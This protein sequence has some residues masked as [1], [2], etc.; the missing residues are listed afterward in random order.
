MKTPKQKAD[1][2]A[3]FGV[4]WEE[5]VPRRSWDESYDAV[6]VSFR[7]NGKVPSPYSCDNNECQ[8]GMWCQTQRQ[9]HREGHLSPE[10]EAKLESISGWYWSHQD[11][12]T[13][14]SESLRDFIREEKGVPNPRSKDKRE[15]ELGK[16][17]VQQRLRY[18]RG[19]LDDERI[20]ILEG[21][22]GWYWDLDEKWEVRLLSSRCFLSEHGHFPRRKGGSKLERQ[23]SVWLGNQRRLEKEGKLSR[24]KILALSRLHDKKRISDVEIQRAMDAVDSVKERVE[25]EGIEKISIRT[26]RALSKAKSKGANLGKNGAVLAKRNKETADLFAGALSGTISEIRAGGNTTIR[27]IARELNFRGI[28]SARGGEW[29]AKTVQR[30]LARIDE[31][32]KK[33]ERR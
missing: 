12:W 1:E 29:G 18:G 31:F 32:D 17:C 27:G 11:K 9:R 15:S 26:K 16:W 33:T 4:R 28:P 8:L 23:L 10:Q 13:S 3:L 20:L 6:L 21:I 5:V 22:E 24:D 2:M 14:A 30:L 25:R 7:C 19:E